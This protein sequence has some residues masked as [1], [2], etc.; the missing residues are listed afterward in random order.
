M[1]SL[2]D[3]SLFLASHFIMFGNRKKSLGADSVNTV[4]VAIIQTLIRVILPL[5]QHRCACVHCL[6]KGALSS[7]QMGASQNRS[8]HLACRFH[9]F[10]LLRYWF[11]W[12]CPLFLCFRRV[13]MDSSKD[14]LTCPR[15]QNEESLKER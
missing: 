5:Q 14:L 7:F 4:G 11:A 9:H 8:H 3:S 1:T 2:F 12:C 10:R 6:D 15:I 13:K